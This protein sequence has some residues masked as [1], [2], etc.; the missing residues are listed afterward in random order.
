G[1]GDDVVVRHHHALG[2]AGGPRGVD[3][4]RQ[5]N[6]DAAVVG[7]RRRGLADGVFE[8]DSAADVRPDTTGDEGPCDRRGLSDGPPP[9]RR[10][11]RRGGAGGVGGAPAVGGQLWR[12][13]AGLSTCVVGWSRLKTAPALSVANRPTTASTPFSRKRTTRSPRATP[14]CRR[15][16]AKRLAV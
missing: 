5:V 6:G 9:P 10:P 15:A 12:M 3:D 1:G 13:S 16:L 7:G 4:H 8:G 2:G 14:L 11:V